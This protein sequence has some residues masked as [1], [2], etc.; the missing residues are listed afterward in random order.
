MIVFFD[1]IL[2]YSAS[3]IDHV[4]YLKCVFVRTN[5]F[6]VK[7]S[8]C[9]FGKDSMTFLGHVVAGDG[10]HSDRDKIKAMLE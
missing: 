8:K 2:I 3:V 10:V 9:S 5:K 1:N 7:L 6:I 4:K